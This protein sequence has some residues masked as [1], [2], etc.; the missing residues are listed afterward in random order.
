MADDGDEECPLCMEQLDVTDKT[1]FPCPC[2]YQIC[3]FCWHRL[4]N[5]STGLCPACRRPFDERPANFVPL[6]H[7]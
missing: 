1:F 2:G 5:E 6:T 7:E 3:G 4:R